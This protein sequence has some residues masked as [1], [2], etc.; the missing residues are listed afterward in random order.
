LSFGLITNFEPGVL[1]ARLQKGVCFDGQAAKA[2]PA[3]FFSTCKNSLFE[4]LFAETVIQ[5]PLFRNPGGHAS[6]SR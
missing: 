1:Q 6:K 2:Q 4:A 3:N 5:K